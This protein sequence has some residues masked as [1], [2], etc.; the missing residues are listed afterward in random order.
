MTH[1]SQGLLV[2]STRNLARHHKPSRMG[3]TKLIKN[4]EI[5]ARVIVLPKGNFSDIPH[6]RYKGS[7]G[8]VLEKRGGAYVVEVHTSKATTRKLIVPQIH[9]EKA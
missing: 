9:L 3:L 6:P 5:G 7:M 1:R 2:G 8:T 4:F